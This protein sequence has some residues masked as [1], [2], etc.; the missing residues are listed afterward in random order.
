MSYEVFPPGSAVTLNGDIA[1]IVLQVCISHHGVQ[2]ECA[3]WVN[4]D[5]K[6]GWLAATEVAPQDAAAAKAK[7]G[8]VKPQ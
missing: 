6:H 7:I 2:Y 8:F 1:A 5:R 3:W 4:G